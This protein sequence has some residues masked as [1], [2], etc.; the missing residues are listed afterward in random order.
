MSTK[1][2]IS[3]A[4]LLVLITG[5]VLVGNAQKEQEITSPFSAH[6]KLAYA[7]PYLLDFVRP[8][9]VAKLEEPTVGADG[10]IRVKVRITDPKG[11]GLDRLGVVTPGAVSM[12]LIG[13]HLP[14]P[15]GQYV[16]YTTR[17]QTSPIT[18]VTAV[19]ASTDSG[20][21]WEKVA[22]G[23]YQYTF[24]TVLPANYNRSETHAI[25]LYATRDLTEFDLDRQ[26]ANDVIEF[27]PD[28]SHP[29]ADRAITVTTNCNNC[30]DPLTAHGEVR[31]DVRLCVLCH[32]AQ[33]SDPDTGNTVDMKVMIHKIHRGE[34]LP[35]VQSGKPY[36]IIGF[37]GAVA[38]FSAVRFP[39]D[40][41]NCERCHSGAPQ[42]LHFMT[43]PSRAACG[44]CHD[45]VDFTTGDNHQGIVQTDDTQCRTC[46]IP[47]GDVEFDVSI[48]GAHTVP[49]ESQALPGVVFNILGVD[50]AAPGNRPTVRFSVTDKMGLPIS[51]A[52]MSS[53]SII[54]AGP[55]TDYATYVRDDAR[56]AVGGGLSY[57]WTMSRPLAAD[58]KGSIAI[59]MEGYRN[60][61]LTKFDNS[62][63]TVRDAGFNQVSYFDTG[64]N[65][66]VPRR[67]VIKLE[68]CNSCHGD[69]RAHGGSRMNTEYCILCHTP[70]ESDR[71]RRPADN[72]PAESIHFKTLIHKIHT[73]EELERDFT[74]YGFGGTANNFNEIR[75]P[76][77]RRDC[78]KCHVDGT[79]QLPLPDTNM[80]TI[81]P[82]D[83]LTTMPPETASCLSC[84]TSRAAA[85]HA[86]LNSSSLGE[87]CAV[88]HGVRGEF[89]VNKVHAR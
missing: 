49:T 7:D 57:S 6:D 55:T 88:C 66:A 89:A 35:S 37:G 13:A 30:H 82:R 41:R 23:L 75:F 10:R 27:V 17:S 58:I 62:T 21:S 50:N 59:G 73:G 43:K 46:H 22:D 52:T 15:D 36:Q 67:A 31:R 20:G 44:A 39:D 40:L 1:T 32:T 19:Q 12:S 45:N 76:G 4:V 77:D 28:A 61:T 42:S 8:G 34:N 69:L 11:L 81:S 65:A 64:G 48:K 83:W 5:W 29:P 86:Q 25:G 24:G 60:V 56:Q 26:Y 2:W 47:Q 78:A 70:S 84:H 79:Q 18:R 54:M 71:A 53:L 38:D 80:P 16:A 72:Q 33:T 85:V 3:V 87:A 68:G 63:I 74:I 51:P 9:L 14:D